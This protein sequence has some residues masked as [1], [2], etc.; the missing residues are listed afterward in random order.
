MR[1]LLISAIVVTVVGALA[2]AR[3]AVQRNAAQ[4]CEDSGCS[5]PDACEIKRGSSCTVFMEQRDLLGRIMFRR[6]T[7]MA[8]QS[9]PCS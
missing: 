3:P 6:A 4:A 7:A 1:S 2:G 5:G 8:C 9:S